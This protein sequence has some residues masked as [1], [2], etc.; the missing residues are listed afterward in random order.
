MLH[1]TSALSRT[2]DTSAVLLLQ[3]SI[4]EE[5]KE[6]SGMLLVMEASWNTPASPFHFPSL[7]FTSG[8][9]TLTFI[10][11]LLLLWPSMTRL[12]PSRGLYLD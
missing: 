11:T 8:C 3:A 6:G 4:K 12:P 2:D 10:L 5:R 7:Q 1:A 9:I